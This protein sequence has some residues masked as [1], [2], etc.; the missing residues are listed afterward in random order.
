MGWGLHPENRVCCY[1]NDMQARGLDCLQ[2]RDAWIADGS[3]CGSGSAEYFGSTD[4]LNCFDFPN[5]LGSIQ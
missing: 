4:R 1:M 3:A 2:N 5:A